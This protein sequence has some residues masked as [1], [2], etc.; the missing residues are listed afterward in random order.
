MRRL[1]TGAVRRQLREAAYETDV[2]ARH[3][4]EQVWDSIVQY[5]KA[6]SEQDYYG[7]VKDPYG[8]RGYVVYSHS[9]KLPH[10]VR[11]ILAPKGA[12]SRLSPMK[13]GE[14]YVIVIGDVLVDERDTTYLDTRINSQ[15]VRKQFVHEFVHYLDSK[16][17]P[18]LFRSGTRAAKA[19]HAGQHEKYFQT[20]EEFNAWFQGTAQEIEAAIDTQIGA[21]KAMMKIGRRGP[22]MAEMK[23]DYLKQELS[24]LSSFL[25]FVA[26]ESWE[27]EEVIKG[28]KGTKWERKWLKRL[29]VFYHGLKP[30]VMER[31]KEVGL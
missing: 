7:L 16:R 26:N 29:A 4:A 27:S 9:T 17:N 6:Q 2:K 1:F 30:R 20:P 31:I 24:S 25:R 22:E 21:A 13:S 28:I 14:G 10:D 23:L 8:Q 5:V 18:V 15:T 11:V 19:A 3:E 12:Q